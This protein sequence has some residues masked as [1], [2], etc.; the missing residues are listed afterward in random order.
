MPDHAISPGT[1]LL[2]ERQKVLRQRASLAQ[3]AGNPS[4]RPSRVQRRKDAWIVIQRTAN[5][6]GATAHARNSR[7][8]KSLKCDGRSN[9][10][11]LEFHPHIIP[12]PSA[13]TLLHLLH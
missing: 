12:F 6:D 7:R 1:S 8:C 2:G 10:R 4:V 11:D 9:E 13:S 5:L 3:I